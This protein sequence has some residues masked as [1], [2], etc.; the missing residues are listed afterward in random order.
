VPLTVLSFSDIKS[1][2]WTASKPGSS[3][4]SA[5]SPGNEIFFSSPD[6]GITATATGLYFKTNLDI[7]IAIGDLGY[8]KILSWQVV[9]NNGSTFNANDYT[10]VGGLFTVSP[11]DFPTDATYGYRFA[12]P[13]SVPEPSTYA[14]ALAGIA[15]GGYSMFRRRKRA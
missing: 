2:S 11:V 1:W 7:A 4:V 10:G 8:N 14:M 15:C 5:N 3:D 12:T 6:G 9:S 13:S